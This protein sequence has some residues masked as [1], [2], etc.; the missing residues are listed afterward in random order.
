[1]VNRSSQ[2]QDLG[3]GSLRD[4]WKT[5]FYNVLHCFTTSPSCSCWD[6]FWVV[7]PPCWSES[8]LS[9]CQPPLRPQERSFQWRIFQ[10]RKL[11]IGSSRANSE[12]K[13]RDPKLLDGPSSRRSW[14]FTSDLFHL[15][16]NPSSKILFR[17][18]WMDLWKIA[19]IAN[20]GI[21]RD[22]LQLIFQLHEAFSTTTLLQMKT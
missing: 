11:S 19:R 21:M 2:E 16:L 5:M 17:A 3:A 13:S 9:T 15:D 20:V 12:W 7:C 6:Q 18:C 14:K 10:V 8:S 4:T 1:M 22:A